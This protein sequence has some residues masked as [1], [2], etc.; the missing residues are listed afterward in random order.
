MIKE[1]VSRITNLRVLRYLI[2]GGT[3]FGIEYV[4]FL[5][6]FYLF[7]VSIILSNTISFLIGFFISF[8]FNRSWTFK[9]GSQYRW[10]AHHQL[11]AYFTLA[12]FNLGASNVIVVVLHSFIPAVFC[13]FIAGAC[14]AA[15]N[16]VI[17]KKT[18]FSTHKPV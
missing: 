10:A 9:A 16:F 15:W 14:I 13:K 6:L 7:D 5:C 17:F 8:V 1:H 3:A 2:A 11:I 12:T 18:I 4:S